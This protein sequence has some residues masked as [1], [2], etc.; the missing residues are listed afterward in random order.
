MANS[1]QFNTATV[2]AGLGTQTFT[3]PPSV[4]AG[5]MVSVDAN[6]TIPN[7]RSGSSADS[8]SLV[9]QSG[10][11]IDIQLNT[12]SQVLVGGASD[13]PTPQQPTLG[14][15]A[16]LQVSPGDVIDVVLSSSAAIDAQANS[17]KG[18]INLYQGE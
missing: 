18:L 12:V 7:N 14:C 10:L 5:T 1:L 2:V 6:F 13:N 9:G 17:V 16:K 11:Q 15:S 4:L 3:V 8:A